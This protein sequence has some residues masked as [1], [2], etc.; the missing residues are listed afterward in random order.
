M[1]R[2]AIKRLLERFGAKP[3]IGVKK[4]LAVAAVRLVEVNETIDGVD[5]LG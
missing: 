2:V 3:A 5:D 1:R 4:S